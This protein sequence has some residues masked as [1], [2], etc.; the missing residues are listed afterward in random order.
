[1]GPVAR[2]LLRILKVFLMAGPRPN[3]KTKSTTPPPRLIRRHHGNMIPGYSCLMISN[4]HRLAAC[5]AEHSASSH[6]LG[7]SL[8]HIPM[9]QHLGHLS[10]FHAPP[11]PQIH[12]LAPLRNPSDRARQAT[13]HPP[14]SIVVKGVRQAKHGV[15]TAQA[16]LVQWARM[17]EALGLRR[18]V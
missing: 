2:L 4:P 12:S 1:M 11:H 3:R 7:E 8:S 15:C 5:H 6:P 10:T 17:C 14:Q 9:H 16:V 13:C 18:I